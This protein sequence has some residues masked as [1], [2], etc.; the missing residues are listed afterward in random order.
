MKEHKVKKSFTL[1]AL[2]EDM[3]KDLQGRLIIT[4][5]ESWG[6]ATVINLMNAIGLVMTGKLGKD[7]IQRVKSILESQKQLDSKTMSENVEKISKNFTK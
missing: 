6:L 4:T 5:K 1:D 7:D 2:I 3:L